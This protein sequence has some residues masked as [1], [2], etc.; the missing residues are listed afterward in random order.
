MGA[1]G[2]PRSCGEAQTVPSGLA[3]R[4]CMGLHCCN[5]R[6]RLV[7]RICCVASLVLLN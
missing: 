2:C 4:A 6:V 3:V 1:A 5:Q 7:L